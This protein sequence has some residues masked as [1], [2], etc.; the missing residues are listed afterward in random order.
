MNQM[1]KVMWKIDQ[2]LMNCEIEKKPEEFSMISKEMIFQGLFSYS[3]I[4]S[5]DGMGILYIQK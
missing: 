5:R 4:S 2:Y 3:W 1:F